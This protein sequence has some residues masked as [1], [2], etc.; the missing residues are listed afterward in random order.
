MGDGLSGPLL[1]ATGWSMQQFHDFIN[2]ADSDTMY[3]SFIKAKEK[4]V[5]TTSKP[6][7]RQGESS[8]RKRKHDSSTPASADPFDDSRPTKL[9]TYADPAGQTRQRGK[10]PSDL[11]GFLPTNDAMRGNRS[12][13]PSSFTSLVDTLNSSVAAPSVSLR[14]GQTHTTHSTEQT[15]TLSNGAFS[16]K[17]GP[18][19]TCFTPLPSTT[20]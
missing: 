17:Y 11:P 2:R 20:L 1:G 9:R 10:S 19:G 18:S 14:L 13:P 15:Q 4:T 3:E 8:R 7:S 6:D 16:T 5:A 12:A